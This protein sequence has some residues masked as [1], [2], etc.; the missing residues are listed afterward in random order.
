MCFPGHQVEGVAVENC[1]SSCLLQYLGSSFQPTN[2][3]LSIYHCPEASD[4]S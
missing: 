3:F 1:V 4:P 2:A